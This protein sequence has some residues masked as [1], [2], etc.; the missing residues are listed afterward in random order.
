MIAIF[1]S[2][3]IL[4]DDAGKL[5]LFVAA[6]FGL[7]WLGR[8]SSHLG[9]SP[10]PLEVSGEAKNEGT[11]DYDDPD[12]QL[13][14]N[15]F[16]PAGDEIAATFPL[17]PSLGKIRMKKFFFEKADAL[18]SPPDPN[19]FADEL[20]IQLYD[21]D[22]GHEWSQSYFVATPLGLAQILRDKS[23]KYLYSPEIL[24]LPRYDLEEIRRAA[25]SRIAIDA[26]FFKTN[27]E[28]EEEEL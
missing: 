12:V 11:V 20:H 24:I 28:P 15:P 8:W 17:D 27:A 3:L 4:T 22:S 25:V 9:T 16:A 14:P 23:W 26:E 5:L 18:A 1:L 13:K 21:P 7:L 19:V 2:N 10:K 6:A